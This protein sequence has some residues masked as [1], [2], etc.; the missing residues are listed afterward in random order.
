M[1]LLVGVW[2]HLELGVFPYSTLLICYLTDLVCGC[3]FVNKD[4]NVQGD[5]T[6]DIGFQYSVVCH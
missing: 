4:E 1:N 6:V 5:G 3:Q 2:H